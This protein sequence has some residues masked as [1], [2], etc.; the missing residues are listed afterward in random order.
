M[1]FNKIDISTVGASLLNEGKHPFTVRECAMVKSKFQNEKTGNFDDQIQFK[2]EVIDFKGNK[3]II[4][5]W[6]RPD[7]ELKIYYIF[8]SLGMLSAYQDGILIPNQ[9]IGHA[10]HFMLKKKKDSS[11]LK[12]HLYLPPG[13]AEIAEI[14]LEDKGDLPF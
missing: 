7:S 1:R 3:N 4:F 5:D 6:V 8:A 13:E 10:G 2:H 12:V 9:F 14:E 11:R